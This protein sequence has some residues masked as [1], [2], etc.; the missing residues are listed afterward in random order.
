MMGRMMFV[1]AAIPEGE[2]PQFKMTQNSMHVS[3]LLEP[4]ELEKLLP[5]WNIALLQMIEEK[6]ASNVEP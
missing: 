3:C 4:K 1:L 2:A 5:V 6:E